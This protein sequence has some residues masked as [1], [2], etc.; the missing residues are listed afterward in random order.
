M[1]RFSGL[2]VGLLLFL[3]AVSLHAQDSTLLRKKTEARQ[4]FASHD[5]GNAIPLFR[6]L[7]ARYPKE[8]EYLYCTGVCLVRQNETPGE[9][10][11]LLRQA[12]NSG[13]NPLSW[14]YLGLSL[15]RTYQ[16]EDA[17]RAYSRF[18]LLG[19]ESDVKALE[20]NRLV[21]MAKNG[22]EYTQ[23]GR[24]LEV[25]AITGVNTD[26]L[27]T[28]SDINGSGKLVRKPVEFCSKTDLRE[29]FRPLMFLPS[30]TEMNDFVYVA[31][32]EKQKKN[33]K[34]LYRVRNIN[35]ETWSL[36][37]ALPGTINTPYDEEYPFF[38]SK[39]AVLYFSSKGHSSMGGY[40][41]FK[42]TYDWNTK[43]WSKPE[44][45]GFP[46]NT[47][48]DDFFYVTD[49]YGQFATFLSNRN[50]QPGQASLY[51]IRTRQDTLVSLH[52]AEDKVQLSLPEVQAPS[53]PSIVV[54]PKPASEAPSI[55][56]TD[57]LLKPV[58]DAYARM[59]SEAL[60][61]QLRSDSL[62][63]MAREKRL[64]AKETPDGE[65]KRQMIADILRTEKESKRLQRDADQKYAQADQLKGR[66]PVVAADTT[67]NQSITEPASVIPQPEIPQSEEAPAAR[68]TDLFEISEKSPYNAT[69]P[70]P[71]PLPR[72]PGL[73]YRIQLGAFSKPRPN[74]AF[75]GIQPIVREEVATSQVQK[76][77]A[78]LFYGI[79]NVNQALLRIRAAGFPDAFVVAFL[80]GTLITTEK[81]REV[82]FGSMKY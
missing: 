20:V 52:T 1:I 78:G 13:Y 38:D 31:G 16:F 76:Y 65:G 33:R 32:Y 56:V 5:Y 39:N 67:Y 12:N 66:I 60:S 40:D 58:N 17:I 26:K 81:A 48:Y 24:K 71:T 27:E 41:I 73:V 9:A 7:L 79:N 10:I 70:I 72:E 44:N 15:H 55:V 30:Y 68:K 25:T 64:Q 46:V 77:Y 23:T 42:T 61:L 28:A 37:E 59:I 36:P 54:I 19:K 74:D 57:S 18:I 45:L 43:T 35:H 47:P 82:E 2:I 14:Y 29:G 11:T 51:K 75:G 34:Q 53:R 50:T 8:P 49:G 21:E 22:T 69:N 3:P 63:R 80:D 6:E 62:S 4:L